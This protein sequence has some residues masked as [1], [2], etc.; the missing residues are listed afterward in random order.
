MCPTTVC[1][2]SIALRVVVELFLDGFDRQ[3]A[4][5]PQTSAA[6]AAG[7]ARAGMIFRQKLKQ[8]LLKPDGTKEGPHCM[9]TYRYV[10]LF[11]HLI[12]C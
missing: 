3:P 12:T 7:L 10:G 9:D 1:A 2:F 8:G 11:L 5:L 4:H 6:R